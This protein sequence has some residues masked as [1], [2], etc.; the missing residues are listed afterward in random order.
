MKHS[1]LLRSVLAI[2]L[3][4]T[5][6]ACSKS[7]SNDCDM[8]GD[9]SNMSAE[10]HAAMMERCKGQMGTDEKSHDHQSHEHGE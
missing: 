7:G 9:M 5:L 4:L 3:A 6:A 8:S 10:E 2:G 1:T